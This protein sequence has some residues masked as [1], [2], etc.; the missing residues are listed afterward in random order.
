M[1]AVA[2]IA[3]LFTLTFTGYRRLMASA[4]KA[5]CMNNLRQI[6]AGLLACTTERNGF[7]PVAAPHELGGNTGRISAGDPWLP[8]R[9]FGGTLPAEQRPLHDYVSPETFKSPCDRGEPLWW[10]DTH[11]SQKTSTCYELYGSSYFYAS[12]YNRMGGVLVPMGIA[13]LVGTEFS[14]RDYTCE[15][16]PLGKPVHITAYANPSKKVIVGSIPIHRTMSGVVA[17]NKR[18]QWY[19]DDPDHLWAN[20]AFL[21]GHVEFVRV[22]PYDSDYPGVST[23][24][25]ERNPY[26]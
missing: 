19:K 15:P 18:A 8:A 4:R 12:G 11:A 21:D 22:F 10:F 9:M 25:E 24:P 2:I 23:T 26:Y 16:L 7:Y 6:S 20:A 3:I 5:V 13:K 14:H 17:L 1:L